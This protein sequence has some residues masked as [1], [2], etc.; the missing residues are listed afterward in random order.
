MCTT[1]PFIGGFTATNRIGGNGI[2]FRANGANG[3]IE[4]YVN[5]D[6]TI[7]PGD[8]FQFNAN[9]W[10]L[11]VL[12][13]DADGNT[14][15]YIGGE[16][17]TSG[18]I[19][20]PSGPILANK[21]AIAGEVDGG[22]LSAC[23]MAR[24]QVYSGSGIADNWTAAYIRKFAAKVLGLWPT[25]GTA[26][27]AYTR[28]GNAVYYSVNGP[29]LMA[30]ETPP[31][32]SGDGLQDCIG[33]ANKVYR[34]HRLS[35]GND[36]LLTVDG[37]AATLTTVLD[38]AALST[39]GLHGF[40]YRVFQ[41]ANADSTA[42]YVS[43]G[44][45]SGNTNQHMASVRA[46]YVAG[47]SA[48][49]GDWHT[50]TYDAYADVL[51]DY[52]FSGGISTATNATCTWGVC[53]PAGCTLNFLMG[54]FIETDHLVGEIASLSTASP[55]TT[56][57]GVMT[58]DSSVQLLDDQ[59][60]VE[61]TV[62]PVRWDG[63]DDGTTRKLL[64][65]TTT[66]ASFLDFDDASTSI[67]TADGTNTASTAITEAF[68]SWN[69]VRSSWNAAGLFVAVVGSSSDSDSYDGSFGASGSIT[70]TSTERLVKDL[71]LYN[72]TKKS[73]S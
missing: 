36:S 23:R 57:T 10:G 14:V 45:Q 55:A 30:D 13:V 44:D 37:G 18:T 46:R 22:A 53:V 47:S 73:Q 1:D 9:E 17:A 35:S 58:L 11:G 51:D 5:G 24:L 12:S 34:N 62:Q 3:G 49:V 8:A 25:T 65:H 69:D 54:N 70:V 63:G 19:A 27:P 43:Y 6:S 4:G 31:A 61:A 64:T 16:V 40:G 66:A 59:G 38:Q 39:A 29:W 32:G 56:S 68:G 72:V 41:A 48:T 15:F 2:G 7:I 67:E 42:A 52:A 33:R 20:T 26:T 60:A 50:P 21:F 71:K 28:A